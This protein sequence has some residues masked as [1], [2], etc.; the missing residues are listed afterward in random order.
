MGG[1]K[2]SVPYTV[3]SSTTYSHSGTSNREKRRWKRRKGISRR[4]RGR[5][6]KE[7][8]AK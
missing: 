5:R 2:G 4:G 1:I 8:S 6:E 3:P 7:A